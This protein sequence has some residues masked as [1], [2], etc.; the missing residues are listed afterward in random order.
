MDPTV[1]LQNV[2]A[3]LNA[4]DTSEAHEHAWHLL[5]WLKRDGFACNPD[6]LQDLT[7]TGLQTLCA[8]ITYYTSAP[9]P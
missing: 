4:G 5:E 9:L 8:A 6:P 3:A 2:V 7:R 1:T